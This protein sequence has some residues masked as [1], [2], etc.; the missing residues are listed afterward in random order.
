MAD[1][2]SLLEDSSIQHP[3]FHPPKPQRKKV[4]KDSMGL[5]YLPDFADQLGWL[6]WGA[7][8]GGIS[9]PFVVFGQ[10]LRTR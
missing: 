5:A 10:P 3:I 1:L 4:T 2:G 6:T 7:Y 8:I 9:V